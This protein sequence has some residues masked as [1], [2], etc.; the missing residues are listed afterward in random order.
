MP[1]TRRTP[2]KL[3]R[4]TTAIAV[5]FQSQIR[6]PL[7]G[8][9]CRSQRFYRHSV[10]I[11]CFTTTVSDSIDLPLFRLSNLCQPH[12][13]FYLNGGAVGYRPPVQNDYSATNSESSPFFNGNTYYKYSAGNCKFLSYNNH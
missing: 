13:S 1:G 6:Q 3:K 5:V 7:Q 8:E 11:W 2:Q 10:F 4:N 9:H 12:K